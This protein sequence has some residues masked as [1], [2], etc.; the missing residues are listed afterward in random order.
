MIELT[1]DD[2]MARLRDA[3]EGKVDLDQTREELRA[4]R[5]AKLAAGEPLFPKA[6]ARRM[7]RDKRLRP[8]FDAGADGIADAGDSAFKA[9]LDSQSIDPEDRRKKAMTAANAAWLAAATNAK[10][11]KVAERYDALKAGLATE[12]N[13]PDQEDRTVYEAIRS[14][15][16]EHDARKEMAMGIGEDAVMH[17]LQDIPLADGWK[18]TSDG[19]K[20]L[21]LPHGRDMFEIYRQNRERM[22]KDRPFLQQVRGLYQALAAGEEI[23][24]GKTPPA[25]GDE[26]K[27]ALMDWFA[28]LPADRQD[29]A[30][31]MLV[32]FGRLQNPG[33]G[34]GEAMGGQMIEQL[35]RGSKDMA[36]WLESGLIKMPLPGQGFWEVDDIRETQK[37]LLPTEEEA[38][39]DPEKAAFRAKL[40]AQWEAK[41]KDDARRAAAAKLSGALDQIDPATTISPWVPNWVEQG[42]YDFSRSAPYTVTGFVPHV[43]IPAIF[44]ATKGMRMEEYA[45]RGIT[46]EM[47]D[48]MST[49]S[50]ALETP[51]EWLSNAMLLGKLPGLNKALRKLTKVDPVGG[52][53]RVAGAAGL[54]VVGI[55]GQELLE[56]NI[57][58]AMPFVVQSVTNALGQDVPDVDWNDVMHGE[59]GLLTGE[60]QSRLAAA[61]LPM[62]LLGGAVATVQGF[63]EGKAANERRQALRAL[64]LT[65]R[66]AEVILKIKDPT[67]RAKA[68]AA[69]VFE[70]QEAEFRAAAPSV[71]PAGEMAMGDMEEL[72][73]LAASRGE[74]PTIVRDQKGAFFVELPDG[75]RVPAPT[76]ATA[77]EILQNAR[78]AQ[79]EQERQSAAEAARVLQEEGMDALAGHFENEGAGGRTGNKINF[80]DE[81]PTV[82]DRIEAGNSR[83]RMM[84]SVEIAGGEIDADPSTFRIF[85]ENQ[86]SVKRMVWSDVSNIYQGGD[87]TTVVEENAHGWW[88]WARW[89]GTYSLDEARD[90]LRQIEADSGD[91]YLPANFEKM[92][93][94][95]QEEAIDEA[96]AAASVAWFSGKVRNTNYG[97]RRIREV[98]R[99]MVSYIKDILRRAARLYKLER[100]GR[101]DGRWKEY[102]AASVG[103]DDADIEARLTQQAREEAL[104]EALNPDDEISAALRKKLPHPDDIDPADPLA[105]DYRMFADHFRKIS[106]RKD[107]MGRRQ[108]ILGKEA[109]AFFMKKGEGKNV[110][111]D[112]VRQS[113]NSDHGFDFETVADMLDALDS[114]LRGRPVYGI[115]EMTPEMERIR[116][117]GFE[118]GVN[119]SIRIPSPTQKSRPLSEAAPELLGEPNRIDAHVSIR[120]PEGATGTNADIF[121]Y[122]PMFQSAPGEPGDRGSVT[123]STAGARE[124]YEKAQKNLTRALG[125]ASKLEWHVR[126]N[127][128]ISGVNSR[129]YGEERS[130]MLA[131]YERIAESLPKLKPGDEFDYRGTLSRVSD[132]GSRILPSGDPVSWAET[133]R[134]L[135]A[136]LAKYRAQTMQAEAD[137]YLALEEFDPDADARAAAGESARQWKLDRQAAAFAALLDARDQEAANAAASFVARVWNAYGQHDEIFQCGRTASKSAEDIAA[138]VSMPDK[139]VTAADDGSSVRFIG[140]EGYLD[141]RE[142]NTDR[143]FIRADRAGS[144]GKESG[145]GSQLYAAAL[146]WIHNNGKRIK[147]DPGGISGINMTRRTSNF[148]AS[149]IRHGTT[150]HLNPHA[151]QKVGKWTKGDI[152]NT[153]LLLR[154]EMENAFKAVP[155]AKGWTFDFESGRFKADGRDLTSAEIRE[156]VKRGD[157]EKSGIGFST[158]QRAVITASAIEAFQRGSSE[159]IVESAES[160]LPGSLRGVT[161][162]IGRADRD[163]RRLVGAVEAR[164]ADPQA[165]A[166]AFTRLRTRLLAIE[167]DFRIRAGRLGT[168]QAG[169]ADYERENIA[170]AGRE[171]QAILGILP[172]EAR[173][174]VNVGGALGRVVDAK[175][176]RGRVNALLRLIR[177]VDDELEFHLREAYRE[178]LGRLLKM[179]EAK[180][181]DNRKISGK[182][183]AETHDF[184]D[185][186]NVAM[187]MAVEDAARETASLEDAMVNETDRERLIDLA[188]RLEIV[189][190]FGGL[191]NATTPATRL[192]HALKLAQEVYDSGRMAWLTIIQERADRVAA[193]ARRI[194]GA[195]GDPRVTLGT[196]SRSRIISWLSDMFW[197]EFVS[198]DQLMNRLTEVTGDPGGVFREIS[199]RL[200]LAMN[201]YEDRRLARNR[202]L[203]ALFRQV[204]GTTGSIRV[205]ARLGALTDVKSKPGQITI[206]PARRVKQPPIP[207]DRVPAI[208]AG[209][210]GAGMIDPSTGKRISA[211]LFTR[212]DLDEIQLEYDRYL[213]EARKLRQAGNPVRRRVLQWSKLVPGQA[214]DMDISEM[215]AA[216]LLLLW[217]QKDYRPALRLHGVD[218]T[219]IDEMEDFLSPEARQIMEWLGQRGEIEFAEIDGLHRRLFGVGL[220]KVENHFRGMFEHQTK[221]GGPNNPFG[222]SLNAEGSA[223][224]RAGFARHR[225]THRSMPKFASALQ[226]WQ[227]HTAEVDWWLAHAEVLTEIGQII[228]RPEVAGALSASVGDR[229][230]A[231][232]RTRLQFLENGGAEQA[233]GMLLF[234]QVIGR[235]RAGAS[236]ALLGLKL[237]TL[238]VQAS[239]ALGSLVATRMTGAAWLRGVAGLLAH[240]SRFARMW[241]SA[242]LRRRL[243]MGTSWEVRQAMQ[244]AN[245]RPSRFAELARIGMVP[246]AWFDAFFTSISGAIAYDHGLNQARR[247]GLDGEAA[248][249][250]ALEFMDAVVNETAQPVTSIN[251]STLE[252]RW[253]THPA[254]WLAFAFAT[255]MRQKLSMT[256]VAARK[257]VTGSGPG[258]RAMALRITAA[259]ALMRAME[260]GIRQI[261]Q[262]MTKTEDED[263]DRW[264]DP[265]AWIHAILAGHLGGIPVLGQM[266]DIT[267]AA[268]LGQPHFSGGTPWMGGLGKVV[269]AAGKL[270]GEEEMKPEE[271]WEAMENI[272]KAV[273]TLDPRLAPLAQV[274]N[275]ESAARGIWASATDPDDAELS[276]LDAIEKEQKAAQRTRKLDLDKEEKQLRAMPE[277][278]RWKALAERHAEDPETMRELMSRLRAPALEPDEARL[279]K[280]AVTGGFRARAIAAAAKA[281]GLEGEALQSWLNQLRAKRV[282]TREVEGDLQKALAADEN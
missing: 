192:H 212:S 28:G 274:V 184:F 77:W 253:L 229:I 193:E 55:W 58:D 263:D 204:F 119:Y 159:T 202:E 223:L 79:V 140:P 130:D 70:I 172:P 237:S 112:M 108:T 6:E 76:P 24:K 38:A 96:L 18:Q 275:L 98:L 165:R 136:M 167:A 197:G 71:D 82:R 32:T 20:E 200:R 66:E 221:D 123:F 169:P 81:A 188:A 210:L 144:K 47:A 270:T 50:A 179:A 68:A 84:Q 228:R 125:I 90:W 166:E 124:K 26:Q 271:V 69:R 62:A 59:G 264:Q 247:A 170:R 4:W 164:M 72:E 187:G 242:T 60:R 203:S 31:N 205:A 174:R 224:G 109:N 128:R 22:E 110:K 238:M 97:P 138:A 16:K 34:E 75:T 53:G 101:L 93:P 260:F 189:A 198:I 12:W 111:L 122:A 168:D 163:L 256:I 133:P 248:E 95:V 49:F 86:A 129:F 218:E 277:G 236:A 54:N 80:S 126:M 259:L 182:L 99:T 171:V 41:D 21:L 89:N 29:L 36:R 153:S 265:K 257:L 1:E 10:A 250:S 214:D 30:V 282:L 116:E 92:A 7:D 152:L 91:T 240:P 190:T 233:G 139:L 268:V 261:Y 206:R 27:A 243:E 121:A 132:D 14:K 106:K 83:E 67:E 209:Q 148:A 25:M 234:E 230:A 273:G 85:G 181:N 180:R 175:S 258:D 266:G 40:L 45:A 104:Q 107:R 185:R 44:A 113:L 39:A 231:A 249:A 51:V 64:G 46:P 213:D 199:D 63:T 227:A 281:R 196:R 194:V 61:V 161:Y 279:R 226:V 255:E 117:N 56:E 114:S 154:R 178:D 244:N 156:A 176:D 105:G 118:F 115:G 52:L 262:E 225:V 278:E 173:Y 251:R 217:R 19:R 43:G 137:L 211:P 162:S 87:V 160:N 33:A 15:M 177:E 135:S 8:L 141:I 103:L 143:P 155:E 245:F 222:D 280:F 183:G 269:S 78:V 5:D 220:P 37:A 150:R 65:E 147:D 23:G 2:V 191:D 73:A 102:L 215:E 142:T 145:G 127:A 131:K 232:V 216:Y 57:Q 246:I 201:N 276:A 3:R 235:M 267:L 146:D 239:A 17:A 120:A 186:V 207:I 35:R 9:W 48:Q 252:N 100:D 94:D 134:T 157:P 158:L 219:T 272:L 241:Q 13:L 151:D 42:L 149:S 254:L 74:I 11:S 88:K 195:L 208:L